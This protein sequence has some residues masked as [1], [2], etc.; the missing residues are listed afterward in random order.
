MIVENDATSS[1]S[2]FVSLPVDLPPKEQACAQR[3]MS[4][5]G[6][7]SN[8]TQL[9]V[10]MNQHFVIT[11]GQVCLVGARYRHIGLQ[12]IGTE[13]LHT[14]VRPEVRPFLSL[15]ANLMTFYRITSA[16]CR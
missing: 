3:P 13:N 9:V 6:R 7:S 8:S 16:E 5:Y 15:I 1:P 12:N 11:S 4:D 10:L 2:P 14:R